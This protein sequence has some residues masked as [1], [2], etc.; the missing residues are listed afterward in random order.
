MSNLVPV[1][2]VSESEKPPGGLLCDVFMLLGYELD[3]Y[4][5]TC[6]RQKSAEEGRGGVCA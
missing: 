6:A 5:C 4:K 2:K 1:T 3:F